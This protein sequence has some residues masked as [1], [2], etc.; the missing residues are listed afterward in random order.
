MRRVRLQEQIGV[1]QQKLN[2]CLRREGG[3]NVRHRVEGG[4]N[5]GVNDMNDRG[6][7]ASDNE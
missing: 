3:R 5:T 2:F 7:S 1:E 6:H 4:G